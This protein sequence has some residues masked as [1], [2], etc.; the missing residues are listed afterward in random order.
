MMIGVYTRHG[1]ACQENIVS[2]SFTRKE[3][4]VCNT[5]KPLK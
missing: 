1:G 4:P 3:A 2:C 5:A